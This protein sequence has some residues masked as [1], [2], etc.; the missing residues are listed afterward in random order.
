MADLLGMDP[1][2]IERL[3]SPDRLVDFDPDKLWEVMA[4]PSGPIVD[5]GCGVGYLALP[6][7]RKL[8][9]LTVYACDILEGMVGLLAE[10]VREEG[11]TNVDVLLMEPASIPLPDG[12]GSLVCMGQ[13][14]HELDDPP[15]LLA[16]CFRVLA[17]NGSIAILDWK[18]EENGKSPAA[19]R[20]VPEATIRAQLEAAGFVDVV[21]H[22]VYKFHQCIVARR[23]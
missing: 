4:P 1:G 14:H 8:P 15:P 7:A 16:E 11:L 3:R 10:T 9:N 6:Y 19:G 23:P 20:R 12:A 5:V 17:A 22:D 2:R 13:V 18:D 21:A